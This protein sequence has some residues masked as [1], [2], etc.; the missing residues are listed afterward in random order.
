M[1]TAHGIML[2]EIISNEPTDQVGVTVEMSSFKKSKNISLNMPVSE[3][4]PP[5]YIGE[6]RSPGMS[7]RNRNYQGD[8]E[9]LQLSTQK[10]LTWVLVRHYRSKFGQQVPGWAGFISSTRSEPTKL[11]SIDYYPVINHPITEYKTVQA[12]LKHAEEATKEV[13]QE[14]TVTTFDLGVCMKAYPLIWNQPDKYRKHNIMVGTFHLVGV[15]LK[16]IGK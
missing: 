16:M 7:I 11:T 3:E 6:R 4:L 10:D 2:Q 5:I 8:E 1:H 9:S 12:C 15:Y 14:Y 13:K